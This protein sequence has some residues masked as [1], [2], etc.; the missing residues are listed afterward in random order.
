MNSRDR[1][2]AAVHGDAVRDGERRP[3]GWSVDADTSAVPLDV[4][5]F[6]GS[7]MLDDPREHVACAASPNECT[8]FRD[9]G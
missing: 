3:E 8:A 4:E 5:G 6:D 1:Q 7:K 2:A 9:E